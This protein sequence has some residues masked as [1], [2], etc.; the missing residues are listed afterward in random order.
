MEIGQDKLVVVL[1]KGVVMISKYVIFLLMSL[2]ASVCMAYDEDYYRLNP[3]VLQKVV[4]ACPAVKPKDMT[5]S[6]V[7]GIA[8][9]MNAL[10]NELRRDPQVFGQQ[11]LQLQE[12]IAKDTLKLKEVPKSAALYLALE[13]NKHLLKGRLAVIKWLESPESK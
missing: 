11:V 9:Q 2:S 8:Q 10:A 4:M 6:E 7:N 1:V 5:C 13:E 12:T 3:N